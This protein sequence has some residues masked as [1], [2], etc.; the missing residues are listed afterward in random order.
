M[1]YPPRFFAGSIWPF[2]RADRSI[3]IY[4]PGLSGISQALTDISGGA[5]NA[6]AR[7]SPALGSFGR[8]GGG[9]YNLVNA[10][11]IA[12]KYID[13]PGSTTVTWA[14]GTKFSIIFWVFFS[15]TITE[16]GEANY[17]F[18][19]KG[20]DSNGGASGNWNISWGG[21]GIGFAYTN[22]ANSA[23][24][25]TSSA[26]VVFVRG[27]NC[28]GVTYTFPTTS[29]ATPPAIYINGVRSTVANMSPTPDGTVRTATGQAL[30]IGSDQ[31]GI[32]NTS[33]NRAING[34]IDEVAIW[35]GRIVT[36][37]EMVAYY[38]GAVNTQRRSIPLRAFVTRNDYTLALEAA[39]YSMA[40]IPVKMRADHNLELDPAAYAI[41]G[42]EMR[43]P[44]G[45]PPFPL[46]PA[47]YSLDG[48][49]AALRFGN[50][51]IRLSP[52]A[53]QVNG[54]PVDIK[55]SW[56]DGEAAENYQFRKQRRTF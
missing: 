30:T 40:I 31:Y 47:A 10:R 19:E 39:A 2:F 49:P 16:S 17:R 6:T 26:K 5:R 14:S 56:Y 22:A 37:V 24:Y 45:Y 3:I 8:F 51:S 29:N 28:I 54:A 48:S 1:P 36:P 55:Y 41:D 9:A 52:G 34:I 50:G 44:H 38:K 23:S 11:N 53:Y 20:A 33:D 27:W 7:N 32:A 15:K 35:K 4:L 18:L 42:E 13:I 12:P 43:L 25:S 46:E 21:S